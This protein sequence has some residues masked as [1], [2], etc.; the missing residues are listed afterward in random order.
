MSCNECNKCERKCG[1]SKPAID[2]SRNSKDNLLVDFNLDGVTTQFDAESLIKDGE[3]DTSLGVDIVKRT[4]KYLA[5]KH[6]DSLSATELGQILH[7]SDIGDVSTKGAES[8]STLVYK[9][10]N[11]CASGCVSNNN[12]WESWNAL[13]NIVTQGD[14]L[15]V[16]DENGVPFA[17]S[18]PQNPAQYYNLGWNAEGKLSYQQPPVA[19][20]KR[21]GDYTLY[22]RSDNRQIYAVLEED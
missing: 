2:V 12:Q 10:N 8:G 11:N 1:C 4:L 3:T 18:R 15:N 21:P 14:Y 17:L 20:T 9:K 6:I 22:M 5:E 13:D 16:Y 19:T 7:L